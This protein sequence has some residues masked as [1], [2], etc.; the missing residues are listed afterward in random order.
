MKTVLITGASRGIG[1]A[2]AENLGPGYRILVGATTSAGA[3]KVV[4]QLPHADAFVADL[5]DAGDVAEAVST[6]D[7]L[8]AI[9]HSAG[10]LNRTRIDEA[11][12]TDW[13][14]SFSLNVFAVAELTRQLL[15]KLRASRGTV[16][17]INSG[18]GLHSGAGNALY[19]GTKYALRAFT[20]A[21]REEEMGKIRVT[22]VHPGR[23]NTDMQRQLRA[24][25]GHDPDS[26]DGAQWAQPESVATA[27]RGVLELP[28]DATIKEVQVYPSGFTA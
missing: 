23:V 3:Q 12:P 20:D 15:P 13:C 10:I 18:S 11:T 4:D 22:S 2:I 8:D 25:E 6:I 16:V 19:S 24:A 1:R 7:H 28:E 27:V 14:K 17:T 21:L 5:T 9:V 26:Y